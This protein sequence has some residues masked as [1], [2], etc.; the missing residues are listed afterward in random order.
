[1]KRN[2]R[3]IATTEN[4]VEDVDE[5]D[6]DDDGDNDKRWWNKTT[7]NKFKKT[8]CV[9]LYVRLRVCMHVYMCVRD[10]TFDLTSCS[11]KES[12]HESFIIFYF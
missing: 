11:I 6:D 3:R 9:C 10:L 12:F 4:K 8:V 2:E 5:Y 1:M 7:K